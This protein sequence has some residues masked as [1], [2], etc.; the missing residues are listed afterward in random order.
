VC[1]RRPALDFTKDEKQVFVGVRDWGMV[2]DIV[3]EGGVLRNPRVSNGTVTAWTHFGSGVILFRG[4]AA[5]NTQLHKAIAYL[6]NDPA[7]SFPD[8]DALNFGCDREAIGLLPDHFCSL[9]RTRWKEGKIL[10][11][12]CGNIEAPRWSTLDDDGTAV[13]EGA[14]GVPPEGCGKVNSRGYDPVLFVVPAA[15]PHSQR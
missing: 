1:R 13:G 11:S 12:L 3:P 7:L 4:G 8:Q 9:G 14:F 10:Q 2:S 5:M 15:P 6:R